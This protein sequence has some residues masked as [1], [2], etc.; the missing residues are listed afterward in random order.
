MRIDTPLVRILIQELNP[1]LKSNFWGV[2]CNDESMIDISTY[3]RTY[4][5][6]N[7]GFNPLDFSDKMVLHIVKS[8]GNIETIELLEQVRN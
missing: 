7:Y 2:P 3:I 4:L 6:S 5:N 1:L 8:F